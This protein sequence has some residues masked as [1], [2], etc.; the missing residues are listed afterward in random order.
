VACS[1]LNTTVQKSLQVGVLGSLYYWLVFHN[2][3]QESRYAHSANMCPLVF[4]IIDFF[5]NW[6]FSEFFP[7]I[8]MPFM[9]KQ[10]IL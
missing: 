8:L 6:L 1:G 10:C 5:K 9:V 2:S 7:Y 4:V 3:I